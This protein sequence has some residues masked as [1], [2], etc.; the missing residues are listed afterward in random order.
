MR[1]VRREVRRGVRRDVRR[2]EGGA[3]PPAPTKY[4]NFDRVSMYATIPAWTPIGIPFRVKI[5]ARPTAGAAGATQRIF[6][7]LQPFAY[8]LAAYI[9]SAGEFG[10]QVMDGAGT[11]QTVAVARPT[12]SDGETLSIELDAQATDT[13]MTVSGDVFS[14]GVIPGLY[15]NQ[16]IEF[17][18]TLKPGAGHYFGGFLYELE[19]IDTNNP[20]N[21]RHYK[22]DEGTGSVLVDTLNPGV[23]DGTIV[24]FNEANWQELP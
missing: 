2:G 17:L 13:L 4:Y 19:L 8:G 22:M 1:S 20:S 11:R 3:V 6:Q 23:N 21:S 24:N 12:V 5:V 9:L 16:A 7:S 18:G 10:Y 15:D 14:S